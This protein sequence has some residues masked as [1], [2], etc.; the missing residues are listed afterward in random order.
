[1]SGVRPFLRRLLLED[2]D[3]A[4]LPPRVVEAVRAR[5]DASERLIGWVQLALVL[6]FGALYITAPKTHM[7][8][9]W[10]APVPIALA[11]YLVFTV[12]RL[13]L[14]YRISLPDWYLGLSG[15][16][17]LSLL[18]TLIWFFHIQ[19]E[20]PPPFYLK[21]PTMLYVFI[22]IALRA[23]RFEPRYVLRTGLAAALGWTVLVVYALNYGDGNEMPLT[24]DYVEYLT[25]NRVLLGG[26]L[27]KIL[28]ILVVTGLLTAALIRG[29]K[30]LIQ[31]L[32]E[33][34]ASAELSRFF[35][36]EIAERITRGEEPGM[37]EEVTATVLYIDIRDFTKLS[38]RIGPTALVEMLMDY[39][40]RMTPV[41]SAHGGTV[42]RFTGDGVMASFGAAKQQEDF[43]R[44]AMEA[45]EAVLREADAWA[46]AREAVGKPVV[47]IGAALT[48]GRLIIGAV[49]G[50]G[51]MEYTL[52]GEPANRAA[53][54]EKLN[55]DLGTR[56][57]VCRRTVDLARDQ[58]WTGTHG[59][60]RQN[61]TVADVDAPM[62]LVVL[63]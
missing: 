27:D 34:H 24:R 35:A 46:E 4:G 16:V 60:V 8:G 63:G 41:I 14:S 47:R 48:T 33:T 17:D 22:F 49:G 31:A 51:K 62:D 23:L 37:A 13:F 58:G 30:T 15:I 1:M 39:Q 5:Q 56:A 6:V 53:K 20:Q 32:A 40:S 55:K 61:V 59:A 19:Y 52:V 28:S 42:E 3:T 2:D 21:A 57:L 7:D 50:G 45:L 25:G 29:R 44:R 54:I 18:M 11:L 9:F 26:E 10:G 43:A 38:E 12:I 36:P